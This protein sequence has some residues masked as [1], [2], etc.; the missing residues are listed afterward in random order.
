MNRLERGAVPP[1]DVVSVEPIKSA[2]KSHEDSVAAVRDSDREYVLLERTGRARAEV[3][4]AQA[5][6]DAIGRG[7]KDPGPKHVSAYERELTDAKRASACK[8]VEAERWRDVEQAFDKHGPELQAATEA[9]LEHAL[10][11]FVQWVDEGVQK[12]ERVTRALNWKTFFATEGMSHGVYVK[13]LGLGAITRPKPHPI[14]ETLCA[15][16]DVFDVMRQYGQPRPA[17]PTNVAHDDGVPAA[18]A[19]AGSWP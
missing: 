11:E 9:E 10:D 1:S 15:L 19:V 6:A 18:T 8:I 12:G 4:D 5:T 3:L 16:P 14:D 17:P 13:N 2:L 7:A